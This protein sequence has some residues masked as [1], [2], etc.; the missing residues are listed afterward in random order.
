[1]T[2]GVGNYVE[3]D[4]LLTLRQAIRM[5][6]AMPPHRP[7]HTSGPQLRKVLEALPK[8]AGHRAIVALT[9]VAAMVALFR[10][11]L[12]TGFDRGF[13]DQADGMIEISI[14]EHWRNVLSGASTWNVTKHFYPHA[15]TLV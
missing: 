5:R 8:L 3:R 9:Y 12:A 14:L 4:P 11:P 2:T 7:I 10:G 13:S 15:D 6:A 1:M